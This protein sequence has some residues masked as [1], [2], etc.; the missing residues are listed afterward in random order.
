MRADVR[1]AAVLVLS[2]SASACNAVLGPSPRDANW[3]VI[4][5]QRY[6][7]HVRPNSFAEQNAVRIGEALEDQY[8]ASLSMLETSY[9]GH[10]TA[11][12]YNS[13]SEANLPSDRS[14]TAFPA[15]AAFEAGCTPPLDDDLLA[16]VAHEANHVILQN[17]LGSPGTY[18]LNE[19][20]ASAVLSERYHARGRHFYYA[21][22]R[23]HRAQVP[24]IA[25]L[26]DDG[27]WNKVEE[28]AA[29]SASAS[30]LGYLLETSGASKLKQ[31]Y[32]VRSGQFETRFQEIYGRSVAAAE[33]DW[34]A[35]CDRQ[36]R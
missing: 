17:A 11:M 25:Q 7:L 12:L 22:T 23:Y 29:Y 3:N 5:T 15:T 35:F 33:A 28:Q 21:W 27:Q 6:S 20:L 36:P 31:L 13:G 14:G 26:A 1:A 24:P 8:D 16:L 4:E 18:M 9:T 2:I 19:G 10:I 32:V 34:L 30:F